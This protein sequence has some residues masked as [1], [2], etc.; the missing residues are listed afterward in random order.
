[1]ADGNVFEGSNDYKMTENSFS[2]ANTTGIDSAFSVGALTDGPDMM[3]MIDSGASRHCCNQSHI[4]SSLVR[5]STPQHVRLADGKLSPVL[6]SGDIYLP[7][8]GTITHV[9]Y[10]SQFPINLLSVK[11]LAIDLQCR[12]IFDPGSCSFQDLLTGK[13]IGGGHER[14]GLY[15]LSV[16]INVVASSFSSKTSPFQWHLRLGHPSVSKLRRMFPADQR[17]GIVA[18]HL[19]GAAIR[20]YQ[21]FGHPA[22]QVRSEFF[23]HMLNTWFGPSAYFDYNVELSKMHQKRDVVTYQANFEEISNMVHG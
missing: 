18:I 15:F 20:G 7:H 11:Q 2:Y 6:G 8:L 22:G 13:V 21:W 10:A 4:F 14:E 17:V 16:P 19:E 1:M 12:V 3:W 9:L 23:V 5:F